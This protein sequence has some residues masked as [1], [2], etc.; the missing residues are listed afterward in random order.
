[1]A[2]MQ[3]ARGPLAGAF[4]GVLMISDDESNL[5]HCEDH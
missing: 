3:P 2:H 1:M 5:G 4:E